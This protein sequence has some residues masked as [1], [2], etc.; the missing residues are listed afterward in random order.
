MVP[1]SISSL[2]NIPAAS[3]DLAFGR[4]RLLDANTDFVQTKQK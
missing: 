1:V 4:S 3:K 2:E